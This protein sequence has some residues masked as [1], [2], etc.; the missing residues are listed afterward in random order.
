V[1]GSLPQG[2]SPRQ[3][4][5][6]PILFDFEKPKSR[7]TE[8]TITLL[9]RMARFVVADKGG[10]PGGVRAGARLRPLASGLTPRAVLDNFAT[11]L[12]DTDGRALILSPAA[13]AM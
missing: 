8:E 13:P 4:K 7:N 5:Y 11:I 1:P 12:L 3:R 10:V 6:V 9:A 2:P